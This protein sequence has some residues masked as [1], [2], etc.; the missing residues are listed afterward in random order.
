MS[1]MSTSFLVRFKCSGLSIKE[2][3]IHQISFFGSQ[4]HRQQ[5]ERSPRQPTAAATLLGAAA[6]ADAAGGAGGLE[7]F[8]LGAAAG[9]NAA[10]NWE[11]AVV[12]KKSM[13]VV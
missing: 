7:L 5:S 11:D 6:A 3:S 9:G 2:R 8:E 4:G 12:G 1:I 10:A 13:S